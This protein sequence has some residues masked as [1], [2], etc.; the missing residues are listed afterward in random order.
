MSS[1]VCAVRRSAR[2]SL[3]TMPSGFDVGECYAP[4]VTLEQSP[5]RK[6]ISSTAKERGCVGRRRRCIASV[7]F[8][9]C[10]G[11]KT[12]WHLKMIVGYARTFTVDQLAGFE[13]QL[14][15]LAAAGCQKSLQEQ[16]SSVAKRRQ[17][18]AARAVL[19]FTYNPSRVRAANGRF[20]PMGGTMPVWA[21][22][23]RE[24]FYMS[25]G[26]LM[27]VGVTTTPPSARPLHES[28]RTSL[29]VWWVARA[30]PTTT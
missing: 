23:G 2:P 17:L 5:Q 3:C 12:D 30:T 29:Q 19:K 14:R 25:S 1:G 27:S 24:L 18:R 26:K 7:V 20:R 4:V 8:T 22:N 6:I 9:L 16:V 10:R 11:K 13:A 28:S 15:E 21:Q